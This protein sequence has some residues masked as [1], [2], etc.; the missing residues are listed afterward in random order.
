M[1]KTINQLC[2][3]GCDCFAKDTMIGMAGGSQKRIS[4][5]Q[6]GDRVACADG[7]AAVIRD[8]L[9]G[10][11]PYLLHVSLEAGQELRVTGNHPLL[12]ENG[13]WIAAGRV[14]PGVKLQ[15]VDGGSGTVTAVEMTEY[16]DTVYNLMT[17]GVSHKLLA[18]GMLAGDYD[19]QM[20]FGSEYSEI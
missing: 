3:A 11:E 14:E 15:L 17:E 5:I 6:P 4:E 20:R 12:Q 1:H 13:Q 10:F 8:M 18:N 2:E 19:T 7:E 16:N 9:S